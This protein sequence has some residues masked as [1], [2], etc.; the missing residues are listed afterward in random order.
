MQLTKFGHSCVRVEEDGHTLLI[1]PGSY[2]DVPVA[3]EGAQ[4]VLITH[5]HPDHIDIGALTTAARANPDL[6]IFAPASVMPALDE[7][8]DQVSVTEAGATVTAAGFEIQ[9][10]GGQHA[11]IHPT[12]PL[13]ANVGYIV[14]GTLYHPGD[15]FIV[16]T[17]SVKAVLVPI[18]APWSKSSEVID[19]TVSCRPPQAFQIHDGLLNEF[20]VKS[21]EGMLERVGKQYGTSFH[22]LQVGESVSL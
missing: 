5:E 22:H 6:Q 9:G 15:S 17:T 16:P 12:I 19:F 2:T 20:G 21:I 7:F 14:N 10:I 8:N 1:D 18:H 3:I 11:L 13:V 4:A